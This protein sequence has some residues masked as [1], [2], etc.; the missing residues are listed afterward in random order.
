VRFT[1]AGVEADDVVIELVDAYPA[2]RPVVVASSDRRVRSGARERGANIVSA[3]QLL[4]LL[5]R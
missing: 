4:G 5:R 1:D 3:R 2:A